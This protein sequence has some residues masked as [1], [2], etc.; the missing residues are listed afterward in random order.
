MENQCILP[1]KPIVYCIVQVIFDL[2]GLLLDSESDYTWLNQALDATLQELDLPQTDDYREALYPINEPQFS[3]LATEAGMSPE[4][5]W[6]LRDSKYCLIK[7]EWIESRD[8]APFPNV[9]SL[10]SLISRHDLHIISNSPQSIVDVFVETY[11]YTDLFSHVIGRSS[12]FH[13]LDSLKPSP[14]FFYELQSR[15][16]VS[17]NSYMYVGHSETDER[18]ASA[19]EIPYLPVDRSQ[20]LDL[21]MVVERLAEQ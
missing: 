20:D 14:D 7:R 3:E 2:D 5:L 1:L 18:F 4:E 11:D 19:V 12:D 16:E 9:N 13:S 21:T 17:E 15:I 10:Y 6:T 8:L